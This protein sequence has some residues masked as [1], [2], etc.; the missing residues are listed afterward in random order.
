GRC[1][2][3]HPTPGG[4]RYRVPAAFLV[5]YVKQTISVHSSMS[6]LADGPDLVGF[7]SYSREDDD[8]SDGALSKMREGIQAGLRGDLGRTKRD[9]R[10]RQD[11]TAIAHGELWE[12]RIKTAIAESVFFIPIVTPTAVRSHH[13]KFGFDSFLARE[14]ELGRRDLVFPILY[15]PVPALTGDRWRQDPFLAII[16]SPQCERWQNLRQLDPSSTEVALRI[17]KF[18]ANICRAL[19]QEWLS[20]EE[21]Q[22]AEVQRVAEEEHRRQ[23]G[24]IKQPADD[25]EHLRKANAEK[26][27]Q[28]E[29]WHR[30]ELEGKL[31]TKEAQ[32][33]TQL[34]QQPQQQVKPWLLPLIGA[35]AALL[36][37]PLFLALYAT[38]G[39]K[40]PELLRYSSIFYIFGS[41][42]GGAA[43]MLIRRFGFLKA[44]AIPVIPYALLVGLFASA[45]LGW[46][47][48]ATDPL[49]IVAIYVVPPVVC[50]WLAF[51]LHSLWARK[52]QK[53]QTRPT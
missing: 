7:F 36:V 52:Y 4:L 32:R 35:G 9:F 29:E 21:R 6:S 12:D 15:I 50:T 28:D 3:D 18:C 24:E 20:P 48:T 10:L 19:E 49:I 46:P 40:D 23:E 27:R 13:C 30:P 38:G 47:S 39:T 41:L 51:W 42:Y 37:L 5:F 43:G 53:A 14:K 26:R 31:A 33:R 2:T 45:I 16:A 22:Q 11:K 17:E 34:E 44:V 8:D 1:K 25:E